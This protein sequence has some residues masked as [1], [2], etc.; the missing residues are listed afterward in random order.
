MLLQLHRTDV[1]F[2]VARLGGTHDR[3]WICAL[4]FNGEKSTKME[5]KNDIALAP[6]VWLSEGE[7]LIGIYGVKDQMNYILGIGFVVYK[8]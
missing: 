1:N 2:T 6:E 8:H 4:Y 7:R 3:Q 5:P